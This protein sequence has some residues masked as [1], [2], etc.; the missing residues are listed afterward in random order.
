[1]NRTNIS[2]T[3]HTAGS[4]SKFTKRRKDKL[5]FRTFK[6]QKSFRI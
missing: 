4:I 3:V 5:N 1:M 2:A 6:E